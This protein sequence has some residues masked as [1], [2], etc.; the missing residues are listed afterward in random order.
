LQT[1][2]VRVVYI[3]DAFQRR[4]LMW[5]TGAGSEI[6]KRVAAPGPI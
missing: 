5:S 6:M 1:G 2:V 3:D 4:V